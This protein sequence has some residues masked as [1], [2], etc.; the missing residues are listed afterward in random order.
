MPQALQA[1]LLRVLE[2]KKFTPLGSNVA[3]ES[4]VRIIAATNKNLTEEVKHQKFRLDLFY[5]LNVL[6]IEIPSLRKRPDDIPYLLEHFIDQAN[7]TSAKE[8]PLFFSA[9]LVSMLTKFAW[10]GNIRQL[11]NL[12]K[13][14]AITMDGGRIG[15][16]HLPEEFLTIQPSEQPAQEQRNFAPA[17]SP[18][19]SRQAVQYPESFGALPNSG[20]KLTEFIEDLEN[21]L[22]LQALERTQSNKAQA[23][24]LLGMNRTTL[25][26]RIKKRKIQPLNSPSLEL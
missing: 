17:S 12:I 18:T 24:K 13:R 7:M 20:I 16:E 6:P 4:D 5:R 19:P 15:I 21:N 14:L 9:E 22:I 11:Q 26:E 8:S 23:A 2:D 25:V 1:K 3:K 10:P